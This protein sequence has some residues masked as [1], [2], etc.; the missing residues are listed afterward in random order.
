M[1]YLILLF[2]FLLVACG[3][4]GSSS[5]TTGVETNIADD[6]KAECDIEPEV[7]CD[8]G[9]VVNY[10]RCCIDGE[11]ERDVASVSQATEAQCGSLVVDEPVLIE[12]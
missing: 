10:S 3:D 5:V 11:C 7:D 12:E 4:V 8:Q 9:I 6:P 1:K 2:P